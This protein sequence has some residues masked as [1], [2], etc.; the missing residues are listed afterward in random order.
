MFFKK[1]K[2][3]LQ[4]LKAFQEIFLDENKELKEAGKVVISY[5]RDEAGAR[6]ELGAGGVP[7]F[8][9]RQNRFD[10]GAA[11]FLLGKRRMFD[12][13]IKYLSLD[14]REVFKLVSVGRKKEDMIDDEINV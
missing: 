10:E 3:E 4:L 8:Y 9:D 1:A 5:L 14:E 6:G 13:M 7:Y 2:R 12:L 11:G